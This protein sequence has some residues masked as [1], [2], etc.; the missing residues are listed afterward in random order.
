MDTRRFTG[1]KAVTIF[2]TFDRPQ[3]DEAQLVVRAYGRDD[4]VLTPDSFTFGRIRHGS[5]PSADVNVALSGGDWRIVGAHADSSYVQVSAKEQQRDGYSTIRVEARL[6]PGLPAG[7]W[8]TDVWLE[9]NSPQASRLR[10]PL[11]VEVESGLSVTPTVAS[12]GDVKTGAEVER[13]VVVRG[14]EPFRVLRVEGVDDELTV[15]DGTSEAKA[16][17]VLTVKLKPH[18]AGDLTRTLR[19]VTDLKDD[20]RVEFQARAFV[21]Q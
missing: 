2:V 13:R 6:L 19:V 18:R 16:V 21:R 10:V 12:L 7:R 14:T 8:Y 3:W 9:T 5:S 20:S 1:H 15:K 4:V 11:T 17:H